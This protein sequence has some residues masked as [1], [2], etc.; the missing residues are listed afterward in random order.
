MMPKAVGILRPPA[1]VRTG[2]RPENG[3]IRGNYYECSTYITARRKPG[4]LHV[5]R[6]IA[7]FL[8]V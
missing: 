8:H 1:A 4:A 5:K 7:G 2:S 6:R 3:F